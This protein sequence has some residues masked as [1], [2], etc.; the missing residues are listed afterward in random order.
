[1]AKRTTTRYPFEPDYSVPPGD[2]LQET[3]DALDMDQKELA[4]RTGLTP[5]TIN[6]IVKGRAPITPDTA[7][8][9]ERVTG[10][11]ARTWNNLESNYREQLAKIEDRRRMEADLEWLRMIPTVE[12]INRGAIEKQT[13][14]V[15]LLEVTLKFFGVSNSEAWNNIW[16]KPSTSFRKSKCFKNKP[17]P[18]AT[19]LRLGELETQKIQTRNYDK[20]VFKDALSKIRRLTIESPKVFQSRMVELCCKSGVAL[21]FVPEIKGCPASG[22]TRWLTPD[23]ALIQMSLR[24]KTDD[25]FWFTFFHEAGHVLNDPKKEVF[26]ED[27]QEDK[28]REGQANRFA[29]DFLIPRSRAAE[30]SSLKTRK[31]VVTLAKAIGIAPG[32]V[33]GRLQKEGV[34][35]YSYLNDLKQRFVWKTT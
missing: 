26:I 15:S 30:L 12:I 27:G 32:I 1:V 33:V 9:F 29:A 17:G 14:K 8:L 18:T 7:V 25:H 21:V 22:V 24:Y 31:A 28:E 10:L 4:I 2:T 20:E 5:K 3:I 16:L 13:D 19:W 34:I 11:P 23:K 35:K 6:L